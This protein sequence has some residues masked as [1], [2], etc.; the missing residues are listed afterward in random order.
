MTAT[1]DKEII[2][3]V[4]DGD[5]NAFELL[6]NKY[7]EH[8]FKVVKK[9]VPYHLVEEVAHDVFIRAYQS[10]LTFQHTSDFQHWLSSIAVRTCYDF[11]RKQYRNQE[12]PVSSLTD[13]QQHWLESVISAQSSRSFH[14]EEHAQHAKE[15]LDW[16]MS[17][18]SPEDRMVVELIYLEG[19]TG[20]EAAKLLGWSVANVKVRSFRAR[21]KLQ[22]L[23]STLPEN[24]YMLREETAT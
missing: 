21:K 7:Q 20:K 8:V 4:V 24:Q 6:L 5:V 10:L 19:I 1:S 15:M 9:H 2:Q 11:W 18:L 14:E 22:K 3:R 17:K 12:V 16:A 23:L 13:R